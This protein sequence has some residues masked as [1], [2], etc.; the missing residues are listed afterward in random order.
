[1]PKGENFVL[2]F[3]TLSD[4]FCKGNLVSET[5]M[6]FFY[7]FGPDFDEFWFLP[8]AECSVKKKFQKLG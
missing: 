2:A 1:V 6:D 5:K 3:F 8:P 4:T 7:H